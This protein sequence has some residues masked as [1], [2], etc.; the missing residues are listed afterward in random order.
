[1]RLVVTV[2][3]VLLGAFVFDR[4][5]VPAGA[6]LGA[7]VGAAAVNLIGD[8]VTGSSGVL[9]FLAFAVLGWSIGESVTRG[10][11]RQLASQILVISIIVVVLVLAGAVL[12]VLLSRFGPLDGTTA[13]LATSPGALSQMAALASDTGADGLLVVTVHTIRVITVVLVA[14]VV[15]RLIT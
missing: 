11:A 5:H 14:P 8:G 6:L 1:M 15:I 4:L 9:Q 10:A 3:A 7:V 13:Y 2:T 12:A